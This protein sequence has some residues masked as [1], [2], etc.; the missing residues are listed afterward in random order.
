MACKDQD[1]MKT[2]VFILMLII[3]LLYCGIL[4]TRTVETVTE[5]DTA[6]FV[7]DR[8]RFFLSNLEAKEKDEIRALKNLKVSTLSN[9]DAKTKFFQIISMPLQSSCRIMKRIGGH[10]HVGGVG[11]H[12]AVDG[13][14]FVCLDQI[15]K[16]QKCIIYSFGLAADWTFEDMMDNMGCQIF[17][18]DHTIEAP[19]TRGKNINYFKTGLGFGENLKPL[20]Q[21]IEENE[22]QTTE[23]DYL[24]IDIE[25]YEF[26]EGGLT[27]WITSGSLKNVG[28]IAIE[29]H[30]ENHEQN[31]R[32]YIILLQHLQDLYNLGFRVIS[33]EPN[34]V[35]GPGTDGI[36]NFV[37]IVLFKAT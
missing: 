2:L 6:K 15:L 21:L 27:D 8:T 35:K 23:I 5:T 20:S 11:Q 17:A 10:W 1:K 18:Y 31:E 30:V 3:I 34:M 37:E 24:K 12:K 29:L 16:K 33:H 32:Q 19:P 4:K 26:S 22:H 9:T 28:Q 25:E 7:E 36:Y 14:K 13:D